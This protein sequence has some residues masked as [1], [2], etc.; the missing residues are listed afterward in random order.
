M[1]IKNKYNATGELLD[2]LPRFFFG[3]IM[4]D[5]GWLIGI[6]ILIILS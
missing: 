4:L 2:Y 6:I 5:I 3:M 1:V